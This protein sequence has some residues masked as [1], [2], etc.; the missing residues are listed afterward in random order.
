MLR[1]NKDIIQ[2]TNN[3]KIQVKETLENKNVFFFIKNL[4]MDKIF[5]Q[6]NRNLIL[7]VGEYTYVG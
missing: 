3:I 6:M 7:Y 5:G 2:P 1:K 4:D